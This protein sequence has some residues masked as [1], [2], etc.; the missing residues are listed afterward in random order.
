MDS[1]GTFIIGFFAF[2]FLLWLIGGGPHKPISFAGPYITPITDPNSVQTG[3]GP[4]ITPNIQANLPG[5]ASVSVGEK[6]TQPVIQPKIS[7]HANYISMMY[8]TQP[9]SSNPHNTYVELALTSHES[10]TV[11][12]T[13]WKFVSSG[14][15]AQAL[16]ST[17]LNI[18]PG[19]TVLIVTN[20]PSTVKHDTLTLYDATSAKVVSVTY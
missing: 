18:A 1:P 3:Y 8:T 7:S 6:R 4:K 19:Q 15:G 11:S 5:G 2:F 12:L 9:S 10:S 17:N 14:T 13:S 20:F 16:I